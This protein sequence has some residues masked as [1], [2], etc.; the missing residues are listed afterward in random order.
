MGDGI[1]TQELNELGAAQAIARISTPDVE[2]VGNREAE[3]H[4]VLGPG[5]NSNMT[6]TVD[7]MAIDPYIHK[8]IQCNDAVMPHQNVI[9]SSN[10]LCVPVK[11]ER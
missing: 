5:S 7:S 8:C 10:V 1:F 6:T 9:V 4:V 2:I 11:G 3:N